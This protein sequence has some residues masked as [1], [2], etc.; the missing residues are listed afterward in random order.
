MRRWT[1]SKLQKSRNPVR[2]TLPSLWSSSFLLED[3]RLPAPAPASSG[4]EAAR[5]FP[6]PS[7]ARRES[8]SNFRGCNFGENSVI[9]ECPSHLQWKENFNQQWGGTSSQ[10]CWRWRAARGQRAVD[11]YLFIYHL[12]LDFK[13]FCLGKEREGEVRRLREGQ[14]PHTAFY[15]VITV[16]YSV[17]TVYYSVNNIFLFRLMSL[18]T[19]CRNS[20]I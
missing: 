8:H 12:I 17:I 15:S 10:T 7:S 9:D 4:W 18:K 2:A 11:F 13:N 5:C 3:S 14:A 6:S 19:R 1:S 20:R 16:Y